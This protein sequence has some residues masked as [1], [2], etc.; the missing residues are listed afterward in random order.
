MLPMRQR[1]NRTPL[2]YFLKHLGWQREPLI[3]DAEDHCGV[4]APRSQLLLLREMLFPLAA[5]PRRRGTVQQPDA[6]IR[7]DRAVLATDIPLQF[8]TTAVPMDSLL[9]PASVDLHPLA[10]WRWWLQRRARAG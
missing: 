4:L 7:I 2:R 6:G 5:I 9:I 10:V 3:P 1:M 8:R